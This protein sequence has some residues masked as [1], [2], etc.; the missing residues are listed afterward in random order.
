MRM[1]CDERL[2][3]ND[4]DECFEHGVVRKMQYVQLAEIIPVETHGQPIAQYAP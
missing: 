1:G 2:L 4:T 3:A